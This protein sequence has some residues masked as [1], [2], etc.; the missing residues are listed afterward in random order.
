MPTKEAGSSQAAWALITEGVT[1]AR[2][3][4]HRLRAMISRV[5]Q[6]VAASEEKEHLY[7]VAGD[8]IVAAPARMEV[9]EKHLDRTSYALSVLGEESLRD[10]LPLADRKIVDESVERARPLFGPQ[11]H[12][13]SKSV[14]ARYMQREA[15]LSPPLGH[16][17]GPCHVIDRVEQT[18]RNPK[19]RDDLIDDV[20]VGDEIDNS[21]AAQIYQVEIEAGPKDTR[22]KRLLIGPHAQYR[23]DLR[24]VTVPLIRAAIADFYKAYFLAKSKQQTHIVRQME[25]S[26]ARGEKIVWTF[27]RIG[28]TVVFVIN[29]TDARIVT[30]YWDGES[31]PRM[32]AGGCDT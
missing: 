29:G 8:L 26:M 2:L 12:R 19:L 21:E 15:D 7:Q 20:E 11:F 22:V 31:D 25:E 30:T 24:G 17:G 27:K 14:A 32:P 28:L 5:L 3:E 4:A 10:V 9:L 1:S 13:S 18:V 16:P 6:L 23:M